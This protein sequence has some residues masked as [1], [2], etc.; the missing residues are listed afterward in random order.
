MI[1]CVFLF[2][3]DFIIWGFN[4]CLI[5][6]NNSKVDSFILFTKKNI[7][8]VFNFIDKVHILTILNRKRL[9]K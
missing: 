1:F 8:K 7:D 6:F 4:G 2:D 3:F 5:L 9:Q